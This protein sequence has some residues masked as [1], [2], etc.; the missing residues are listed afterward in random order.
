M[1][2]E[3]C[4]PGEPKVDFCFSAKPRNFRNSSLD[5][6]Q[7]VPNRYYRNQVLL[8]KWEDYCFICFDNNNF[9]GKLVLNT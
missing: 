1:E 7:K 6:C 8:L 3:V 2:K 9:S 4:F 5:G